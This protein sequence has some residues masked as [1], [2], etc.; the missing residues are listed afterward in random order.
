MTEMLTALTTWNSCESMAPGS[1]MTLQGHLQ[2]PFQN[3]IPFAW[4]YSAVLQL[5]HFPGE[6]L[7]AS[8]RHRER[9]RCKNRGIPL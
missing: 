5:V 6:T 2:E 3:R 4:H 8:C 1:V 7:N 9:I